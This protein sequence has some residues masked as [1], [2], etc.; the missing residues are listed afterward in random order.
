MSKS[1]LGSLSQCPP[2]GGALPLLPPPL[3]GQGALAQGA[4]AAPS[5]LDNLAGAEAT[6]VVDD[7]I[8]RA[9]RR[10][11]AP[12]AKRIYQRTRGSR[13]PGHLPA[14]DLAEVE[15][16]R[17]LAVRDM[18]RQNQGWQG[19]D[20]W[21]PLEAGEP[22]DHTRKAILD[23]LAWVTD[24]DKEHGLLLGAAYYYF[25]WAE[26][27][28]T[29]QRATETLARFAAEAAFDAVCRQ[30]VT[31]AVNAPWPTV[32]WWREGQQRRR[33]F[34]DGDRLAL[35]FGPGDY[36]RLRRATEPFSLEHVRQ[37]NQAEP[38]L[39]LRRS[40]QWATDALRPPLGALR[41]AA[42]LIQAEVGG[43]AGAGDGERTVVGV[44][45]GHTVGAQ[46][47]SAF[48]HQ[49]RATVWQASR[50]FAN[51]PTVPLKVNP[52]G[53]DAVV[54]NVPSHR[55]VTYT[56][57]VLEAG[58][59]DVPKVLSR[60]DVGECWAIPEHLAGHHTAPLVELALH[61]LRPGGLLVVMGDVLS[62]VHH[63]AQRLI[64]R[65]RNQMPIKV[66]GHEIIRF[67]YSKQPWSPYD[68]L[69][70]TDRFLSAWRRSS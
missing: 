28:S 60:W 64:A 70:A 19:G 26:R 49:H 14:K 56:G 36:Q 69:P 41:L 61:Y 32:W 2:S 44:E 12:K 22:T 42:D 62:G 40:H 38:Y 29:V 31:F 54:L 33:P 63:H 13:Y 39:G 11:G 15:R 58:R 25:A 53:A 52:G 51:N 20:D 16:Q 57:R 8:E 65:H 67:Q 48:L 66:A 47:L 59:R 55:T 6:A 27:F 24:E 45:L 17:L 30:Q 10:S 21:F 5:L 68:G 1:S 23:A 43:G 34:H 18:I 37:H 35:P 9:G 50:M 4:E 46:A 3:A 7:A